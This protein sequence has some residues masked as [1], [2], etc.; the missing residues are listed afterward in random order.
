MSKWHGMTAGVFSV[1]LLTWVGCAVAQ[2]EAAAESDAVKHLVDAAKFA[3]WTA[4]GSVLVDFYADWCG[5]CRKMSP[6]LSAFATEQAGKVSVV[7]V[8]VDRYP[9]LSQKYKVGSIPYLVLF[10]DGKVVD[11]RVGMQSLAQLRSWVAPE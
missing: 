5:P 11:T 9:D 8:N 4:D 10:K 2:D 3:E 1:L 6:A 7:K